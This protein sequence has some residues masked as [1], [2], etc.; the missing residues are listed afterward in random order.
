M[1]YI[2]KL[3]QRDIAIFPM[4]RSQTK[5]TLKISDNIKGVYMTSRTEKKGNVFPY[6]TQV[7]RGARTSARDEKVKSTPIR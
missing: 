6:K 7:P 2:A 5:Q 3:G 1:I 4:R